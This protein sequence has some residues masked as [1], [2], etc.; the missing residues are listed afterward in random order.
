MTTFYLVPTRVY[1]RPSAAKNNR[2]SGR[3]QLPVVITVATIANPVVAQIS[4]P[5]PLASI[6][7]KN[8]ADSIPTPPATVP[9]AVSRIVA[10]NK[11]AALVVAA[12]KYSAPT[13]A[14]SPALANSC[15]WNHHCQQHR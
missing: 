14:P 2:L 12:A 6:P 15:C 5:N 13:M 10:V 1:P 11:L 9:T 8:A 4:I 3:L 7:R